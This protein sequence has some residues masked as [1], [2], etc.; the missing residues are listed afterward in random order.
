MKRVSFY[1]AC[2]SVV[3]FSRASRVT[4]TSC[5]FSLTL[6]LSHGGERGL[7]IEFHQLFGE[8]DLAVVVLADVADA[9]F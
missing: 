2:N 9:F 7:H 3:P 5:L 8:D 6:T 4:R 1:V